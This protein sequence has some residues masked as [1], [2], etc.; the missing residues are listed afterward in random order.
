MTRAEKIN[1][2]YCVYYLYDVDN[3][4]CGYVG[5]TS[6]L[7]ERIRFHFSDRSVT[8]KACWIRS[9]IAINQEIKIDILEAIDSKEAA[10]FWEQFYI[11]YY[12]S[13]GFEL[14]NGT[15][16]GDGGKPNMEVRARM[17]ENRKGKSSELQ[18][19]TRSNNGKSRK[20]IARSAESISKGAAKLRGQKK[21]REHIDKVIRTK[22]LNNLFAPENNPMY[23][24]KHSSASLELMKQ[25][26][27]GKRASFETIKKLRN[28]HAKIKGRPIVIF[29]KNGCK[30]N[31]FISIREA[32]RSLNVNHQILV[33]CLKNR[34]KSFNN[35]KKII[36]ANS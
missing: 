25:A 24:K 14:K 16:G 9:R 4:A 32:A 26:K 17:S 30:I 31:D 2:K 34:Q 11:S 27:I 8:P 35:G 6:N 29:D 7:R 36:Y 12:K 3:Y 21:T 22:R 10:C 13:L 5:Y 18:K 19:I 33:A 20:G 28:V 15:S 23:G 1:K